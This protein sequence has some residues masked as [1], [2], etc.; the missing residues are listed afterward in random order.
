MIIHFLHYSIIFHCMLMILNLCK[1]FF[2]RIFLPHDRFFIDVGVNARFMNVHFPS[3]E[4]SWCCLIRISYRD[5]NVIFN[6]VNYI[7]ILNCIKTLLYYYYIYWIMYLMCCNISSTL[8]I[9]RIIL[10]CIWVHLNWSCGYNQFIIIIYSFVNK[11]LIK[12]Y[13][14]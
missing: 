10:R 7:N 8:L 14:E 4:F 5:E 6:I 13:M 11:V 2:S 12:H 1:Y 3:K 9:K